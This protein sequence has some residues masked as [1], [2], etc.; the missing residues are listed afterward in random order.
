MKNNI[1][2]GIVIETAEVKTRN[3]Y[4]TLLKLWDE[5]EQQL[6]SVWNDKA[7]PNPFLANKSIGDSVRVVSEVREET[8][9]NGKSINK[10][11]FTPIPS[12][13]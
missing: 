11:Y 12:A 9:M 6:V 4:A 13:Q 8:D 7:K 3:G 1:V 5:S 10:T 2:N